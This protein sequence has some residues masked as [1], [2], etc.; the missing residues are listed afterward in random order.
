MLNLL[1]S[2]SCKALTIERVPKVPPNNA[3]NPKNKKSPPVKFLN[4]LN[5]SEKNTERIKVGMA[6]A[7][8]TINFT[9]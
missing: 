7:I 8:N 4:S 9:S 1:N 3:I 5:F 6:C 2:L